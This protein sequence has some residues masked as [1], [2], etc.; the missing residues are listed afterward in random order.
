M[1][2]QWQEWVDQGLVDE[3]QLGQNYTGADTQSVISY[4][5]GTGVTVSASGQNP[6]ASSL[7]PLKA[8]GVRAVGTATTLEEFMRNSVFSTQ[9]ISSLQSPAAY[10]RMKTLQQVIDGTTPATLAQLAPLVNDSHILVRRMAMKALG[11]NGDPGAQALLEQA[12]FD[13]DSAISSA[14][15]YALRLSTFN[16][17]ANTVDLIIAAMAQSGKPTFLEEAMGTLLLGM[18]SNIVMPKM[19][20]VLANHT[21][22]DARRLA[23]R[24]LWNLGG[25]TTTQ[26]RNALATALDDPDP[27]V[28]FYAAATHAFIPP[29]NATIDNLLARA[30]GSDTVVATQ[31][32]TSIGSWFGYGFSTAFN[33]KQDIINTLGAVFANYGDNATVSNADWGYETV[34]RAL[35]QTGNDGRGVL[36]DYMTQRN[37]RAL[38]ERAWSI[39]YYK[40]S[41]GNFD[42]STVQ[43]AEQAYLRRPRWDAVTAMSDTFDSASNGQT[44]ASYTPDTGQQWEVLYGDPNL[45]IIQDQVAQSGMAMELRRAFNSPGSHGV[46]LTGHLYDAAVAE[47]TIVTAKGD[48]LRDDTDTFGWFILDVGHASVVNNPA[49][50][51]HTTGTYWVTEGGGAWD[52]G[53]PIGSEGWETLE[54]VITWGIAE[55]DAVTGTYDVFL[56]RDADNTLG[57][58]DRMLIADD[59]AVLSTDLASL[60]R[61]TL[62]NDANAYGDAVTWW[63]N[64]LVRVDP[65]LPTLAGDLNGDGF[66]GIADLNIVL[67]AWN[68]NVSAG[69]PLAGDPSGDGFVGIEDLN[70]VLG[71]WNAGA[72]PTAAV[73]EPATG[74][75]LLTSLLIQGRMFSR[76]GP[77]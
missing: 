7:N 55:D 10:L 64:I 54:I 77:V 11:V 67:G 38:S 36:R 74:V 35:L 58:L 28:R 75:L 65:D 69:D 16:K 18:N 24:T 17:N 34:G 47:Q 41:K 71:N 15:V 26:V 20:D 59:V 44:L 22:T 63:D 53:V 14:A 32:T 8:Q 62:L 19:A 76:K 49:V 50:I 43:E 13:Q 21:N 6:Y 23:A 52:T 51:M 12:M 66:V 37:D 29:T 70:T 61:L 42:S 73:P 3:L 45:Q 25:G 4:T 31:A 5:A 56:T 72:P 9:P 68:Q 30:A 40:N 46:R 1:T 27:M 48:W 39:L 2:I 57:L 60:Q 33:R